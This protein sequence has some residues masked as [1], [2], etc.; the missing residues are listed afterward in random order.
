M[1][2]DFNGYQIIYVEIDSVL[3]FRNFAIYQYFNNTNLMRKICVMP[4]SAVKRILARFHLSNR[5]LRLSPRCCEK[6]SD[7]QYVLSLCNKIWVV[8]TATNWVT[9]IN[10][11]RVGF[12]TPLNLC[13]CGNKIFWGDYGANPSYDSVNIYELNEC[14]EMNT[15]YTFPSGSV[16][17]VHNIIWDED[18][19]CFWVL[20]GDNEKKAGIYKATKDW[21]EVTPLKTGEQKYRAVVGFPCNGGLIYATDSVEHENF[22][23]YVDSQGRESIVSS[24]NGSCIYGGQVKDYYLFSTTVESPEGRGI[25]ALLSTKLGGGI[26]NRNVE[27][28][29]VDKHTSDVNTAK[30]F[31]KDIW[32]M[33]LLQYG[34]VTIPSGQEYSNDI[35]IQPIACNKVD[36]SNIN[37]KV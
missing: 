35:W 27:L 10:T 23:Y 14:L 16:R 34:V 12:S 15:V 25:S 11:E 32:P 8:N 4:T 31:K 21:K 33:K 5:L 1:K 13:R 3:L 37:I 36:G 9:I 20:T 30:V 6:L 2:T 26:K 19:G 24:I 17:H 28:L 29:R 18:Q 7:S 22:I